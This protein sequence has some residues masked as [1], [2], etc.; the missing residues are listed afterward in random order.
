MDG[1]GMLNVDKYRFLDGI[2][3]KDP[4]LQALK[5]TDRNPRWDEITEQPGEPW[6]WLLIE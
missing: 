4:A 5:G 1:A 6:R 2:L 3:S